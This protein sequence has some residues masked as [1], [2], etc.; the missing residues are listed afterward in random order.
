M[1]IRERH[2]S[3]RLALVSINVI[4]LLL[5]KGLLLCLQIQQLSLDVLESFDLFHDVGGV[6]KGQQAEEHALEAEAVAPLG[7]VRLRQLA[8]EDCGASRLRLL[9][10]S[11]LLRG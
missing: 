2:C 10:D 7:A 11:R 9:R 1:A 8:G 6:L 4:S 5:Q 3:L